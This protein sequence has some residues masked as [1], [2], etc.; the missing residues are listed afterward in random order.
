MF[1]SPGMPK[2]WETPSFSRHSTISSA[3]VESVT[4]DHR[5]V[6]RLEVL[7]DALDAAL[8]PE[9]GVLDTTERCRGVGDDA[10]V[11]ADHAGLETLDDARGAREVARVHVPDEPVLGRV[12]GGDP[13][14]LRAERLDRSDGPEDLL[15]QEASAVGHVG[16]HRWVVE[17]AHAVR[18]GA[19][20]QHPST[21]LAR[22]V[23]ELGDLVALAGVDQRPD[24]D[25]V[26]GAAADLHGADPRCERLSEAGGDRLGDVE[27]IRRR[28]RLAVVAHLRGQ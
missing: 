16:Q 27:A 11:E 1:S 13:L 23:D 9:A 5:D 19:A 14:L 25:A 4:G 28:A 10:G 22:V 3:T 18:S 7:L 15:A 6:L 8:A 21:A 12:G 20:G 24:L 26:L 17:V 2:T